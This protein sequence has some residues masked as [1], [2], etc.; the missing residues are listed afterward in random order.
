MSTAGLRVRTRPTEK[1]AAVEGQQVFPGGRSETVGKRP[2]MEDAYAIVGELVGPGSQFYG[3]YDGHGGQNVSLFILNNLHQTIQKNFTPG[4][5]PEEVIKKSISTVAQ[6]AES[7]FLNQGSTLSMVLICGDEMYTANVGDSRIILIDGDDIHQLSVDHRV[8][9]PEESAAVVKRG[10]TIFNNR[11]NGQLELTRAIGDGLLKDIISVEPHMTKIH[12]KDGMK[13][14]IACDGV[15]DYLP[16]E[17][18][19]RIF[20]EN[21]SPGNAARAIQSAA[22]DK[23]SSD[24]IT[25]ICVC[26]TPK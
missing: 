26:L 6:M 22:L 21:D 2:K 18:V 24:N 19:A 11:V 20:N 1:H 14:V 15:W 23:G 16:N 12:R 10:G 4:C 3:V 7:Q 13:L 25:V 8:T 9:N 17:D 5:N